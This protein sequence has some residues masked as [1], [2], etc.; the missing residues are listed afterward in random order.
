MAVASLP[1][2]IYAGRRTALACSDLST[3]WILPFRATQSAIFWSGDGGLR[4]ASKG[5][6]QPAIYRCSLCLF[7]GCWCC[8]YKVQ[9]NRDSYGCKRTHYW[10]IASRIVTKVAC[11]RRFD[12]S[13][14]Y[15]SIVRYTVGSLQLLS[16]VG[17]YVIG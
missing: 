5:L 7:H 13:S 4:G 11:Q 16:T 14:I 1:Q 10:I 2:Q 9:Y 3:A 15:G 8:C 17:S 12:D 6:A